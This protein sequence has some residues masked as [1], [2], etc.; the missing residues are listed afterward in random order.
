MQAALVL[1]RD[2]RDN[3]QAV[4][5]RLK[6][7]GFFYR[8]F[9]FTPPAKTEAEILGPF[10]IGQ[11]IEGEGV[12]M[13]FREL[14]GTGGEK[15][16]RV[17][18][19]YSAPKD[20]TDPSGKKLL[21][22]FN[23]AVKEVAFRSGGRSFRNDTELCNAIEDRSYKGELFVPPLDLVKT[24]QVNQN[25]GVFKGTFTTAASGSD[26]G[27]WY[28]SSTEHR[29]FSSYVWSVKFSFGGDDWDYKDITRLSCRPCRVKEASHLVI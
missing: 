16:N 18:C 4:D 11:M 21:L 13:G 26:Y 2:A 19:V 10:G 29:V 9:G 3:V 5:A 24:L 22:T 28:W 1:A 14:A 17:F 12:F 6:V 7:A 23:Q 25:E 15:L 27:L 8:D 20:L